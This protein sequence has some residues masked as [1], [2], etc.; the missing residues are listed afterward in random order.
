MSIRSTAVS[1][2]AALG[3]LAGLTPAQADPG[4]VY[5]IRA[6]RDT[7]YAIE[8]VADPNSYAISFRSR[9]FANNNDR[10]LWIES[11][12][13]AGWFQLQNKLRSNL[14]LA[15]PTGSPSVRVSVRP[16]NATTQNQRWTWIAGVN[17][18]GRQLQNMASAR[19]AAPEHPLLLD[20]TPVVQREPHHLSADVVIAG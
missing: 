4:D 6:L 18:G 13:S 16:C 19:V 8:V 3:M 7:T 10:Q 20:G 14:C 1:L 11:R 15:V 5:S 12:S 2:L 9:T 17:S